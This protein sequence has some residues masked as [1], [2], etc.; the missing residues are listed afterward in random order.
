MNASHYDYLIVG[1]GL[2]GATFAYC[3]KLKGKRC[4]VIEKRNHLG[5]NLYCEKYKEIVIHKYGP[6]I[7]HTSNKRVWDFVTGIVPF[8]TFINSPIAYY[9]GEC[10]N[11]P[12]NMNTF[13]ELW[14]ISSVDEARNLIERQK[15]GVLKSMS[16]SGKSAPTNLEEQ[17]LLMVGT[18]VYETMIK[19]YSQKQWGRKCTELPAEIIKRIPLRFTYDN[20]YYNDAWQGIPE[21]GYNRLIEGLLKGCECVTDTDFCANRP[22]WSSIA[23][24][25]V[26]TGRIDEFY[27]YKFGSLEYRSVRFENEILDIPDFQGNAVVNYTDNNVP[28][29][30]IIEHKHFE[31]YGKEVYDIPYT[32]VSREYS[33][34]CVGL[35]EPSYPI[36]DSRNMIM[37]SKYMS[38]AE[39]EQNVHFGGRLAEYKYYDMASI[40]ESVLKLFGE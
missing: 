5:G 3:A 23:D 31:Y 11:L 39:K 30:R 10:Y 35:K 6:H 15:A 34:E 37:L 14:N 16:A 7:F 13:K 40:V 26:Y 2:Y 33:E 38:M 9:K 19:G 22:Y 1:S 27:D 17:A 28:F 32:V 4:L 21:G 24:K 20:N 29:T 18:D 8:R 12:F 36:N 25:F